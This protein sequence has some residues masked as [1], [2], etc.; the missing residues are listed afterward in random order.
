M[1]KIIVPIDERTGKPKITNKMKAE[2]CGEFS[3][4]VEVYC[5]CDEIDRPD[6]EF[7][8]GTQFYDRTVDVPWTLCKD[9]YKKMAEVA[10][11]GEVITNGPK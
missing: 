11:I 6:C 1:N 4:D 2:C 10:K 7:C 3:F 5:G 8:D 9:I